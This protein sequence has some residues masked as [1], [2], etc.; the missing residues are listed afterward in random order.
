M[1]LTLTLAS[2][3]SDE[4]LNILPTFAIVISKQQFYS[5]G[6]R[7]R[8]KS[9]CSKLQ[10]L[11]RAINTHQRRSHL[12][13]ARRV[14]FNAGND[15]SLSRE[16]DALGLALLCPVRERAQLL[17]PGSEPEVRLR[18]GRKSLSHRSTAD[19]V[20]AGTNIFLWLTHSVYI[21]YMSPTRTCFFFV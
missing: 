16:A 15:T 3:F 7:Y 8:L 17:N 11:C 1:K 9:S 4:Q 21:V 5:A 18:G 6:F 10:K 19:F 2:F 13:G 12:P 20:P 14:R